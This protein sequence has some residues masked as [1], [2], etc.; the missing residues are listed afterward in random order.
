MKLQHLYVHTENFQKETDCARQPRLTWVISLKEIQT[1][2]RSQANL[3]SFLINRFGLHHFLQAPSRDFIETILLGFRACTQ[4]EGGEKEL[5]EE[6]SEGGEETG[7]AG[8]RR[9]R[10][11]TRRGLMGLQGR[12]AEGGRQGPR[13][14]RA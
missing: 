10:E 7:G 4:S 12:E 3:K 8:N 14:W 9:Y 13:G 11:K 1:N 6:R 5:E 2:E